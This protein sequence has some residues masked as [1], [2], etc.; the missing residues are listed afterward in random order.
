[1]WPTPRA[2]VAGNHVPPG[3]AEGS[4]DQRECHGAE[5]TRAGV[6]RWGLSRPDD[7]LAKHQRK[8]AAM[9]GVPAMGSQGRVPTECMKQR[10]RGRLELST[11]RDLRARRAE[12]GRGCAQADRG[13]DDQSVGEFDGG[14]HGAQGGQTPGRAAKGNFT[15][16]ERAERNGLREE[17]AGRERVQGEKSSAREELATGTRRAGRGTAAMEMHCEGEKQ[18]HAGAVDRALVRAGDGEGI[19]KL[20][21]ELQLPGRTPGSLGHGD[22][23]GEMGKTGPPASRSTGGTTM[24]GAGAVGRAA[25]RGVPWLGP[26][27]WEL[28]L[29]GR[30]MGAGKISAREMSTQMQLPYLSR[31]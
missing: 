13:R 23:L 5:T 14:R 8:P 3:R 30:E 12:Q 29:H 31:G 28:E 19:C 9:L 24:A 4:T 27:A 16:W 25:C 1:M 2:S 26:G 22:E 18:G 7:E 6:L 21:E 17:R 11:G 15:P 20:Q 10:A